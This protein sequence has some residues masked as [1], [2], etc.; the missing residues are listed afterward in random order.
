M[1]RTPKK[2]PYQNKE[3]RTRSLFLLC[4]SS[5]SLSLPK[6][7]RRA[8]KAKSKTARKQGK[9]KENIV[10]SE[11]VLVLP[12]RHRLRLEALALADVHHDR[13]RGR[14]R[15]LRVGRHRLPVVEHALRE[16]LA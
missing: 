9:R 5:L 16:R 8:K 10:F 7:P 13:V 3:P 1:E 2:F 6:A 12:E 15:V 14:A 11:L 4:I